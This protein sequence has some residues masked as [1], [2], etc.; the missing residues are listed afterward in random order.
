MYDKEFATLS[1]FQTAEFLST[2][3]FHI[4]YSIKFLIVKLTRAILI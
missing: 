3:K 4:S 2:N 1:Y